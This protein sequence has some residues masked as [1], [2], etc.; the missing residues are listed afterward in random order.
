MKRSNG[1]RTLIGSLALVGAGL[2][3]YPG[4]AHAA[5]DEGAQALARALLSP[6]VRPVAAAPRSD[7]R[8]AQR[9]PAPD[10][11]QLAQRFLTGAAAGRAERRVPSAAKAGASARLR[12]AE[13]RHDEDPHELIRRTI[14]GQRV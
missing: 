1:T 7:A 3:A 12:L 6:A 5:A 11:V 8:A 9:M 14:L 13:R 10:A 4:G 2:V